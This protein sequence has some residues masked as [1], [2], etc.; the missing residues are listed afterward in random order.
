MPDGRFSATYEEVERPRCPALRPPA[1]AACATAAVMASIAACSTP[2]TP[3]EV[4]TPPVRSQAPAVALAGQPSENLSAALARALRPAAGRG[5]TRL[6]LAVR[7]LNCVHRDVASYRGDASFNTASIS[8]VNI[9]AALLLQAQDEG[10]RLTGEERR[11]AELMIETS[12]NDA[13][14]WLWRVI[15]EREGLDAANERLGLSST[16][17]GPGGHWG[18]TTTTAEDQIRLLQSI[19]PASS[20][21]SARTRQGLKPA[22]R[23]FIRTLMRDITEGQDWGVSAASSR[24]SLKNGWVQRSATGLWVINSIGLVAVDGHRYLISAL[25]SGNPSKRRG[26]SL[27]ERAVRAAI[28]TA[29]TH[30]RRKPTGAHTRRPAGLPLFGPGLAPCAARPPHSGRRVWRSWWEDTDVIAPC[31]RPR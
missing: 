19:F 28:D 24:W 23:A 25:S 22:S 5:E 18:L 9:L 13:A 4:P 20:A 15:G 12:D 14:D 30:V 6:A 21:H 10:R 31:G 2:A 27:I 11:A 26:I 29:G 3:G 1:L 17:G 7:D 8:K 16:Q